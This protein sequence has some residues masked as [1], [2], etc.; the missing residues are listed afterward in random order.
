ML[1]T[2]AMLVNI[3]A[4]LA[5]IVMFAIS[6]IVIFARMTIMCCNSHNHC[7]NNYY[8]DVS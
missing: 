8:K 2:N 6:I 3:I 1:V 5:R 4:A 7:D